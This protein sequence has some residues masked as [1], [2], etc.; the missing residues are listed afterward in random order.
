MS[1]QTKALLPQEGTLHVRCRVI[2]AYGETIEKGQSTGINVISSRK[3]LLSSAL[4]QCIFGH[5]KH[6][7]TDS[8]KYMISNSDDRDFI[9]RIG[10]SAKVITYHYSYN[11]YKGQSRFKRIKIGNKYYTQKWVKKGN[12]YVFASR[13]KTKYDNKKNLNKIKDEENLI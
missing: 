5:L 9:S 10:L 3:F 2:S 7:D 4:T 8:Y 12:R 1:Y 11:D 6:V 13:T